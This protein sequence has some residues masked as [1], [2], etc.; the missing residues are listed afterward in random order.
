MNSLESPQHIGAHEIP[1]VAI[2]VATYKRPHFLEALL[3]SLRN[4][5]IDGFRAHLIVA[6]NDPSGTAQAILDHERTSIP[7]PVSYAVE[8]VRGIA[9]TRN[10]LVREA[11]ALKADFIAFLDDDVFVEPNWLSYLVRAAAVYKADAVA[12]PYP[13]ILEDTVPA[14]YRESGITLRPKRLP[15]GT[16]IRYGST[17][18]VLFRTEALAS[19]QG[20]FD[21]RMNLSGG[22]DTL[23]FERF[24]RRGLVSIWC[25]QAVVYEHWPTSR[26]NWKY[27]I[28]RYF[29]DGVVLAK[30]AIWVEPSISTVLVRLAKSLALIAK[31]SVRLLMRLP[32]GKKG[33]VLPAGEVA[34]GVGGLMGFLS[35]IRIHREYK[36]TH[37]H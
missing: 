1:L 4:I 30:I 12:G 19:I 24:Y 22:S 26:T 16:R 5:E 8:P 10:R 35:P 18:N 32:S 37:G 2:C 6:D 13:A 9:S 33:W 29:R 3:Q 21:E 25:D 31:N 28:R 20:P 15:T 14:W 34:R 17:A 7:T 27:V 23:L 36:Q 11:A